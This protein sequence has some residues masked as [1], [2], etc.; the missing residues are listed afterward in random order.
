ME[1]RSLNPADAVKSVSLQVVGIA[2]VSTM[3]E[4]RTLFGKFVLPSVM[5]RASKK[6]PNGRNASHRQ[7]LFQFAR[8]AKLVP[9]GSL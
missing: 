8:A 1:T 3:S 7:A 5:L 4:K 9:L 2:L 6:S